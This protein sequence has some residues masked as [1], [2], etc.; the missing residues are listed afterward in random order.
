[1]NQI[2]DALAERPVENLK[3]LYLLKGGEFKVIEVV[4]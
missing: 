1:M 3:K 4:K 2:A